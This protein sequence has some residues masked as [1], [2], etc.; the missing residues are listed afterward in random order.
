LVV[1]TSSGGFDSG[2]ANVRFETARSWLD[3]FGGALP[4]GIGGVPGRR[5]GQ[6]QYFNLSQ[7]LVLATIFGALRVLH[8]PRADTA[9]KFIYSV[10]VLAVVF[11]L[12]GAL[13]L[14][15]LRRLGNMSPVGVVALLIGT[16]LFHYSRIGQ[17]E[18]ILALCY[19]VVLLGVVDVLERRD[20]GWLL[21]GLGSAFAI[22]TRV[23][24]LPT[25][26]AVWLLLSRQW[27][28]AVRSSTGRTRAV[29][30]V[31]LP[32]FAVGITATWNWWRFGSALETGYAAAFERRGVPI[33]DFVGWPQHLAA[34]LVSPGRGLLLYA[35]LL[36]VLP[37]CAG[38]LR[39]LSAINRWVYVAGGGL[40]ILNLLFFSLSGTWD[41]GFGW[42]PR[43][44][45]APLVFLTPLVGLIPWEAKVARTLVALSVLIQAGSVVLPTSTEDHW[46]AARRESG[47]A[48]SEWSLRCSGI[49][50]RPGLAVR[51][52]ANAVAN[53]PLMTIEEGAP[54]SSRTALD[55]SDYL[56]PSW[57]PVRI[58]Y[59]M[60]LW[61]PREGFEISCVFLICAAVV[62]AR[63]PLRNCGR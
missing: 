5:G 26:A 31:L 6:F 39:R 44:L 61:S 2:D 57:W 15:L 27:M 3:G 59:R 25:I 17:E 40:F 43:Y 41:G 38:G 63:S 22:A 35:P 30:A 36:L 42:G 12:T 53:Q 52:I 14:R 47:D 19:A 58:A 56:A 24:S 23:A 10:G 1:A 32:L 51:A 34:L 62:A 18:N 4:R 9:A 33:F 60:S 55:S 11:A 45:V 20:T 46:A 7:S 8:V 21:V 16:P 50:L 29:G 48:C 54:V 13:L 37:L 49:W 28:A